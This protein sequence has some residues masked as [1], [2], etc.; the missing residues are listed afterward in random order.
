[1][2]QRAIRYSMATLGVVLVVAVGG[3][4]TGRE[5]EAVLLG[6]VLGGAVQLAVVWLFLVLLRRP[7]LQ[8]FG[9]GVFARFGVFGVMALFVVPGTGLPFVA[10]LAPL[11]V[12]FFLTTLLEPL[13]LTGSELRTS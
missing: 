7:P 9:I 8:V 3:L 5:R 6:A 10:T 12:V 11:A 2:M 1:V 4:L 13:V